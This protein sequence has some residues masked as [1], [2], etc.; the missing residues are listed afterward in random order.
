MQ[1]EYDTPQAVLSAWVHGDHQEH[2]R[3]YSVQSL[4]VVVDQGLSINSLCRALRIGP[5]KFQFPHTVACL[6]TTQTLRTVLS[7]IRKDRARVERALLGEHVKQVHVTKWA[8][9]ARLLALSHAFVHGRCTY[10]SEYVVSRYL[11]PTLSWSGVPSF[12]HLGPLLNLGVGAFLTLADLRAL[13]QVCTG[14][15]DLAESTQHPVHLNIGSGRRRVSDIPCDR[16]RPKAMQASLEHLQASRLWRRDVPKH[17]RITG[18]FPTIPPTLLATGTCHRLELHGVTA[19]EAFATLQSFGVQHK[20]QSLTIRLKPL[21]EVL[22]LLRLLRRLREW[23]P[24]LQHLQ[25]TQ[26]GSVAELVHLRPVR[27][28]ST[29][30]SLHLE[31]SCYC[32]IGWDTLA[33]LQRL[34]ISNYSWWTDYCA[35]S[36]PSIDTLH[37]LTNKMSDP[38][39]DCMDVSRAQTVTLQAYESSDFPRVLVGR[40]QRLVLVADSGHAGDLDMYQLRQ[41]APYVH[42]QLKQISRKRKRAAADLDWKVCTPEDR[43]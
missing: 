16:R 38:P 34:T 31:L 36:A 11:H 10:M 43:M 32:R 40:T 22:G 24:T 25:L 27:L 39:I 23:Y 42:V 29:L 13:Q 41:H 6:G 8:R 3:A 18:S 30:Q 14:L 26:D 17:L 4:D 28:P 12:R 33:R 1:Y 5:D 15:V 19:K 35:S 2:R 21:Q 37:I 9:R 7:A 20:V